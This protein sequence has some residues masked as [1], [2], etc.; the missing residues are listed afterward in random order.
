MITFDHVA[1]FMYLWGFWFGFHAL[2]HVVVFFGAPG[3]WFREVIE[4][5]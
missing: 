3:R 1:F 5:R 4:S 2:G